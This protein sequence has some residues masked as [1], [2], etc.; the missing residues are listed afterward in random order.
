M[1][2]NVETKGGSHAPARERTRIEALLRERMRPLA[3][4]VLHWSW[5]PGPVVKG[6]FA[7]AYQAHH[8]S[9]EAIEWGVRSFIATPAFLSRCAVHGERIAVDRVPYIVGRPRLEL[10][11]D[12]RISGKLDI[13][14]SSEGRPV[15]RVGNGVYIGHATSFSIGQLVEIGDHSAI[16]AGCYIADTDG[17]SHTRLGVP[18]WEDRPASHS[19]AP[20]IIEDNVHIARGCVILKGVRIGAR[21]V[22][23]AGAV[24][25]SDV[26][27]G[28]V[29]LGNPG[30]PAAWRRTDG[31]EPSVP[32]PH[33]AR[34]LVADPSGGRHPSVSAARAGGAA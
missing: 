25:R 16:G 13:F 27:P 12:I 31:A 32:Q 6:M 1:G 3:R 30:R 34:V 4:S 9:R 22:I 17:H 26:A 7:G 23:G 21:S 33:S 5:S 18:I 2:D 29:I 14:A 20:V 19:V 10:G 24:V 11:S 28:S 8:L 15:L